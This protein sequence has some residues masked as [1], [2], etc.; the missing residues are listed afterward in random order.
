[1]IEELQRQERLEL[2]V[3]TFLRKAKIRDN[4]LNDFNDVLAKLDLNVTEITAENVD[5]TA[6]RLR[7]CKTDAESKNDKFTTFSKLSSEI[8]HA[9]YHGSDEIRRIERDI[10]GRW[11]QLQMIIEERERELTGLKKLTSLIRDIETLQGELQQ[12]EQP[13][14]N[15]DVGKHLLAIDDLLQKHELVRTN[16]NANGKG[17]KTFSLGFKFL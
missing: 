12:L 9:G 1:M 11:A 8:Q 16:L 5:H 10:T 13:L 3:K 4:L 7:T 15:K 2:I 14:R 6:I 17:L